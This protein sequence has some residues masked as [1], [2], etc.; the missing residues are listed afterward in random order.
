MHMERFIWK[1]ALNKNLATLFTETN[2]LDV[3]FGAPLVLMAERTE[4]EPVIRL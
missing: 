3:S 1:V 2:R 4:A